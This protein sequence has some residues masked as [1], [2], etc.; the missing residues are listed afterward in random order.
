MNRRQFIKFAAGAAAGFGLTGGEAKASVRQASETSLSILFDATRCVGCRLCEKACAEANHLPAPEPRDEVAYASVRDTTE[1]QWLVMNRVRHDGRD[2]FVRRSCMHCETPACAAA[3][4][5]HA[6]A[7]TPQ[8]PVVWR[9]DKCIGCRYCMLS[10]PFEIPKYEYESANPRVQKC[11]LCFEDVTS[12]RL[13]ACVADCPR[14]A[15][16]FGKRGEML[17]EAK[18]RIYQHPNDYVHAIYGEKDAGGTALLMISGVPFQ[19]LGLRTDLDPEPYPNLTKEFL[20]SVPVVFTAVPALLL[21][22]S[23][24]RNADAG[25]DDDSIEGEG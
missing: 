7:K 25:G 6:L 23:R 22:I 21:G 19:Q 4:L 10:C 11:R 20:Y 5:T 14:Q 3:C 1:K 9:E 12:G 13:P 16:V 15:I 18:R 8:G 17:D 24:A 2:V